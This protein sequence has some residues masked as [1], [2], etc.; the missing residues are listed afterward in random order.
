MKVVVSLLALIALWWLIQ[1]PS[2]AN[3]I[4]LFCAAGVNPFTGRELEPASMVELLSLLFLVSVLILFRKEVRRVVVALR[5]RQSALAEEATGEPEQAMAAPV[6]VSLQQAVEFDAAAG[7]TVPKAMLQPLPPLPIPKA[8]TTMR[9][10]STRRTSTPRNFAA[11]LRRWWLHSGEPTLA[12]KLSYVCRALTSAVAGVIA[13]CRTAWRAF[14]PHAHRFD[15]W[16]ERK[17]H[18]HETTATLVELG[19]EMERTLRSWAG[20]LRSARRNEAIN[21]VLRSIRR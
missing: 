18:K 10:A 5:T 12:A 13:G 17:V 21:D 20:A 14:E 11:T 9:H 15:S 4:M 1:I 3:A 2:V 16:L 19:R 8:I 7:A 6:A